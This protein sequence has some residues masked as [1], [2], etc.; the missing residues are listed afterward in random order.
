MIQKRIFSLSAIIFLGV[1]A[2]FLAVII[3]G[4]QHVD[5]EWGVMLKNLEENNILSIRD[6]NGQ[7][8]PNVFMPPLYPL[9]LYV[10]KFFFSQ[11]NIFLY[12]VYFIQ[13]LLSAISIYLTYKILLEF[14]SENICKIGTLIYSIFPLNIYGASQISS[15]TL[16]LFFI[17]LFILGFIFLIKYKNLYG[18]ITFSISAGFLM[19]LRGEFFIFFL[20]SLIFYLLKTKDYK[21]FFLGLLISIIVISPYLVRNYQIF[22]VVT[23]TKSGGYNLLKG[24]NPKSLVEGKAMMGFVRDVVPEVKNELDSLKA[25][26]KYDLMFDDI[27]LNQAIIF[28]QEDPSRYIYLYFKRVVSFLFIDL[29]STYPGYYSILHII[30]K[31]VIAITTFFS[32]IFLFRFKFNLYSYFILYYLLNIGL[33][34]V[35]F[36]LP[37]YSLSLLTIQIILSLYWIKKFFPKL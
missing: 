32:I 12:V 26:K 22:E 31:L 25:N 33:F 11:L 2:R 20:F 34:S 19:L 15:I 1:L 24:N 28:I 13:I 6:V 10:I 23:I 35:F 30:P 3:V 7:P 17:N 14:Y 18:I 4:D 8:M 27:L 21:R 29:E 36:I 9:F 16:Q 5:N 37:R